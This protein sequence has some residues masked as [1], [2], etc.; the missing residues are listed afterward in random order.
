MNQGFSVTQLTAY[1]KNRLEQDEN[2]QYLPVQGEISNFVLHPSGHM[3]FTLKDEGSQIKAAM[4][5]GANSRLTFAP[6]NGQKVV[7]TGSVSVY[8]PRGEYQLVVS[9]MIPQGIGDLY[10]QFEELK[11]KLGA[12][13]LFDSAHKKPLPRFPKRIGVITSPSGAAVRDIMNI[14]ARRCPFIQLVLYPALVQGAGTED[15]LIR[16]LEA[17]EKGGVDVIIIGRG[18]GSMEDLWGFNGERLARKIYEISVPVVSAV[19]HET[20]FTICDFVADQRAPTPSAAAELTV[21]DIRTLKRQLDDKA[22]RL[23][24]SVGGILK[25]AESELEHVKKSLVK[26]VERSILLKETALKGTVKRIEGLSPLAVLTRG[27]AVVSKEGKSVKKASELRA[28]DRVA[29]RFFDGEKTAKIE[30]E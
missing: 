20:D 18:G 28:G 3:Y 1:I 8:E 26:G 21:P 17:F 30:E 7:V 15:S 24:A 23:V 9:Q 14:T 16:G 12:E 13:G 27:F 22:D 25:G 4:F 6:K 11:R 10:A 5:K 2:L 29:L 19:G